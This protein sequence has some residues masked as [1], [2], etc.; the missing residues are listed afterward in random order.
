VQV[1]NEFANV[2]HRK[3]RR[4]WPEVEAA[5]AVIRARFPN[6]RS[7]TE[8]GHAQAVALARDERVSFY[9]ALI[10]AAALE[11]GCETLYSEDLQAGRK[12][13]ALTV[14]NPFA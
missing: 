4:T 14:V 10:V 8:D 9:D 6:A 12:F 5:L 3:R 11:A 1:L 13:G 7:L 2:A